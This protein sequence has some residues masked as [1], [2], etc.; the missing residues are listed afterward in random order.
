M[1]PKDKHINTIKKFI[2]SDKFYLDSY[3]SI[4]QKYSYDEFIDVISNICIKYLDSKIGKIFFQYMSVG[5]SL[6]I[7]LENG[8]KIHFKILNKKWEDIETLKFKIDYQNYLQN[9][10]VKT[11]KYL[12]PPVL[13]D[14]QFFIISEFN[15]NGEFVDTQ[16]PEYRKVIA[17]ELLKIN[18]CF[19]Q[20][21]IKDNKKYSL[22]EDNISED[23]WADTHNVNFNFSRHKNETSWINEKMHDSLKTIK[24]YSEFENKVI[25][26]NDFT[27]K[28]FRFKDGA[29]TIIYDWDSLNYMSLYRNVASAAL[30]FPYNDEIGNI[31]FSGYNDLFAFFDDYQEAGNFRFNKNELTLLSAYCTYLASYTCKCMCTGSEDKEGIAYMETFEMAKI[32]KES[33]NGLFFDVNGYYKP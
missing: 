29:I 3:S 17:R 27:G 13:Q 33:K 24:E 31:K 14:N 9:N 11:L 15:Q 7:I 10:D 28:H 1:I 19:K 26:H 32:I 5:Y 16:R 30:T 2:E 25:S 22:I 21:P 12:S 18:N 4:V 20:Y 23:G 8:I 6:G